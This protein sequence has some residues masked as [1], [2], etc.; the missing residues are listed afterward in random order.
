MENYRK[1]CENCKYRC[2]DKM[3]S[4]CDF[5][6]YNI[7]TKTQDNFEL[8]QPKILTAEETINEHFRTYNDPSDPSQ[9]GF[10]YRVV[11]ELMQEQE[12]MGQRKLWYQEG[13]G[14]L[15]EE[16]KKLDDILISSNPSLLAS[17]KAIIEKIQKPE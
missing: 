13:I 8:K 10:I 1:C 11:L 16:C 9:V 5:C 2:V 15:I 12:I 14:D 17:I 6:E 3:I 7:Y 4:P